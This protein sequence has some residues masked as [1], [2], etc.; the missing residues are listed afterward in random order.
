[1]SVL[2]GAPSAFFSI[3]AG[4]TINGISLTNRR[5]GDAAAHDSEVR[6]VQGGVVQTAQNKNSA[7]AW[8]LFTFGTETYGGA[9]DL[10]GVMWGASDINDTG[11]GVVLSVLDEGASTDA[12]NFGVDSF[13]ITVDFDP[14]PVHAPAPALGSPTSP[15]FALTALALGIAGMLLLTRRVLQK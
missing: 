9:T 7:N 10:W 11:F 3:P 8:H 13:E 1:M 12:A 4:S 2:L 15:A 5:S 14:P 6:I